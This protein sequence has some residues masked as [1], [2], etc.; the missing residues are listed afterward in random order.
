MH[1]NHD[2]I[3]YLDFKECLNAALGKGLL[4]VGAEREVVNRVWIGFRLRVL[5]RLRIIACIAVLFDG[6]YLLGSLDLGAV[7]IGCCR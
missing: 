5:L 7:S 1:N 3:L 6:V 4:R 2:I